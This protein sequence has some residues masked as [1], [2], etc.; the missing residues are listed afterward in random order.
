MCYSN[1]ALKKKTILHNIY[2]Y[3]YFRLK[4]I[5][6]NI[7]LSILHN[8]MHII[9][10]YFIEFYVFTSINFMTYSLKKL[11]LNP[12]CKDKLLDGNGKQKF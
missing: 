2:F 5:I 9:H 7:N 4:V 1:T 10:I 3:K 6:L 11:N 12:V 8:F